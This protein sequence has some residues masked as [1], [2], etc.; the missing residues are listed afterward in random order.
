M[1][2][3]LSQEWLDSAARLAHEHPAPHGPNVC[4]QYVVTG[5]PGGEVRYHLTYRDGSLAGAAL[6]ESEDPDVTFTQTYQ[7]AL[8]I[9]HGSLDTNAAFME[10]R[11]K[12]A[13]NMAKLMS[14]L[15]MTGSPPYKDWLE[16]LA[17]DTDL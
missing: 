8:D 5:G 2:R 6:G 4:I 3:F 1:A 9:L 14:V 11:M 17:S 13:G 10:G 15:P 7:D 16:Q 12:V